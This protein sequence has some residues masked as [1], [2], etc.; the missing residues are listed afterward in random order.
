MEGMIDAIDLERGSGRSAA[1]HASGSRLG[2]LRKQVHRPSR[3]DDCT[4]RICLRGTDS[5]VPVDGADDLDAAIERIDGLPF[6]G[7]GLAGS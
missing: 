3:N 6:E 2:E 1:E 4:E 7:T 5:S